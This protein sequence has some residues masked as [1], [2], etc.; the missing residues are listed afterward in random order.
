MQRP[1]VAKSPPP[2]LASLLA[3]VALHDRVAFE[4][5]YR[6]TSSHLLGIAF[7]VLGQ[8]ERAEEVLQ[9]AYMNVW[10]AAASYNAAVATPMTW[11]INIVRNKAIDAARSGRTEKASTTAIDDDFDIAADDRW[12]PQHLLDE[13]LT[14]LNIDS[15]MGSLSASQR[16]AL[17]LAYY[18]GMVHTEIAE[19][20]NAP[21]GTAKAWVRRGLDKL[22]DCL[23]A[24]GIEAA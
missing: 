11:M 13:S 6:A 24:A 17:A 21:L 1:V 10:H 16:Q 2:D 9:E 19:A 15:C 7:R 20:L 22:K 23:Q 4:A 5:L 8:R 14:K 12:E 3:R 18:R